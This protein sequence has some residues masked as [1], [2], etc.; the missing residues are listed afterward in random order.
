M[1]FVLTLVRHGESCANVRHMLS[2]W[3]DVDLTDRG[4]EELMKMRE[5]VSYPQSDAYFSSPL[6]RCI[7]TCHILFPEETP[8]VRDCFKEVNFR[9]LEGRIFPTKEE[10]DSYFQSWVNDEPYVDE[11][12][13]SDAKERGMNA[14][15]DTVAECRADGVT[16]ATIVM[17]SGIMRASIVGLFHLD[18][19]EFLRM[20]VPNGL[21]YVITFSDGSTPKSYRMISQ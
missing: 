1:D 16:S 18:K 4:K 12:T 6:R 21:G 8:I 10:I 2:G 19:S 15:Y 17:H 9:S 13:L 7:E 5:T 11:E 14:I 3:L 20:S